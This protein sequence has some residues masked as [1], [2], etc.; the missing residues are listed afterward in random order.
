MEVNIGLSAPQQADNRRCSFL[1]YWRDFQ[2]AANLT[3]EKVVDLRVSRQIRRDVGRG[4]DV[5]TLFAA[6]AKP[7]ATVGF[8]MANKVSAV[9]WL[10]MNGSR[11]V[12]RP[13]SDRSVSSRLVWSTISTASRRFSRA[14]SIVSPWVFAPGSSSMNAIK[15]N[16]R[17][18]QRKPPSVAS[19]LPQM[20]RHRRFRPPTA[21]IIP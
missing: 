5:E 10:R 21:F 8:Q 18:L 11:V 2:V 20:A 17:G 1:R 13:S 7:L 15:Q 9:H 3:C 12:T 14:S 19:C 6:F 4:V 16:L